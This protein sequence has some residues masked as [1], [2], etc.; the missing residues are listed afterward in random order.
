MNLEFAMIK[1][2]FILLSV[3]KFV[4]YVNRIDDRPADQFI[5]LSDVRQI[6][7]NLKSFQ[8]PQHMLTHQ[9]RRVRRFLIQS[10]DDGLIL[11]T[12]FQRITQSHRQIA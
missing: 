2:V 10:I 11:I 5:H 3:G 12:T 6:V 1:G 7:I 4:N 9:R 8:R